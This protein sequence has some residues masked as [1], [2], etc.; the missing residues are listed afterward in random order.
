MIAYFDDFKKNKLNLILLISMLVLCAFWRKNGFIVSIVVLIILCFKYKTLRKIWL[1]SLLGIFAAFISL[2]LVKAI[3]IVQ[4]AHFSEAVSIP[5][6]Q[7]AYTAKV[8]DKLDEEQEFFENIISINEMKNLYKENSSDE[9]KFTPNFNDDFLDNHK[10]EFLINWAKLGSAHIPEYATA[11]A[12]Q[13]EAFW[14]P[15]AETWFTYDDIGLSIEEGQYLQKNILE[16][17]IDCKDLKSSMDSVLN[18]FNPIYN[19]AILFYIVL[20]TAIICI[21]RKKPNY[22]IALSPLLLI[23][24]SLMLSTPA[25]DFRYIYPLHLCLPLIALIIFN[26]IRLITH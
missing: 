26:E 1:A 13:T 14:K 9:I 5:I 21:I 19:P 25:C 22:I 12:I 6:Q 18:Q 16:N 8:N 2:T 10:L 17:I 3:G 23:W 7:I 4:S 15:D 24:S 11:W 20:I